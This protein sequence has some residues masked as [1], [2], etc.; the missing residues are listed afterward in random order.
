MAISGNYN[1]VTSLF[2]DLSIAA[3]LELQLLSC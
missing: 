2:S 3:E 1:F